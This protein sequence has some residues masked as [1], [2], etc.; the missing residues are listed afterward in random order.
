[1]LL[2]FG[3]PCQLPLPAGPEHGRTIPLADKDRSEIPQC[4]DLLACCDTREA[5]MVAFARS[6]RRERALNSEAQKCAD[7][8]SPRQAM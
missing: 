3:A 1:M 4:S 7:V 6:W 5:A 2:V 8:I